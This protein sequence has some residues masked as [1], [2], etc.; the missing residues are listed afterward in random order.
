MIT[1]LDIDPR[2]G[3]R[4][5][6]ANIWR[7]IDFL[8][9]SSHC[10]SRY[11]HIIGNPPYLRI[12]ELPEPLRQRASSVRQPDGEPVGPRANIWYA[13]ICR[14]LELLKGDGS[15]AFVLPAAWE[16]AGYASQVREHIAEWF[17][18]VRIYRCNK[19]LFANV[20]DGS[21][22]IVAR[23][24][25]SSGRV[26]RS[27]HKS[28]GEV[29]ASLR[30]DT[31][32]AEVRSGWPEAELVNTATVA[33]GDILSVEIGA[34]T[35]DARYFMLKD[36]ER[37]RREI[38]VRACLPVLSKSRHLKTA[39]IGRS[40]WKKLRDDDERVWLFRPLGALTDR[41]S[42]G[43]YLSL[44]ESE[45]GCHRTA[46]KVRDRK[47][48][49][50]THI[51]RAADGFLSGNSRVGPWL[52]FRKMPRL[53]AT[54]TLYVSRFRHRLC[55]DEQAAW[56]MALLTSTARQSWTSLVRVYPDGLFKVEPGDLSK[57]RIPVPAESEGADQA[58]R[59]AIDLLLS[60]K[61]EQARHFADSWMKRSR[62]YYL[63]GGIKGSPTP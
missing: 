2:P 54:N 32:V 40:E 63:V 24:K 26:E 60:G 19:S 57:M 17:R 49:H 13:F 43:A 4:D 58:Y 1:A 45:G 29:V 35:G 3:P 52:A 36:S 59:R 42:V 28:I 21:V 31:K 16:Y 33:L 62:S 11:D 15:M 39:V 56:A 30:S 47:P 46:Y 20:S 10:P 22:V 25:G 50:R 9:W 23:G 14:S 7:G 37:K 34:V 41:P 38:P 8:D 51:P 18:S 48:W 5:S 53:S 6:I 55:S 61:E 12:S 27:E 44:P